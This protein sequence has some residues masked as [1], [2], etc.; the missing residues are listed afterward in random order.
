MIYFVVQNKNQGSAIL[1]GMHISKKLN[2]LGLF[3]KVIT[4]SEIPKD[5]INSLFIW[6]KNINSTLIK[7]LPN[8]THVYDVVDNYIINMSI[9]WKL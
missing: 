2:E 6:V 8:N 4:E 5:E 9:V 1:R 7:K 3:T